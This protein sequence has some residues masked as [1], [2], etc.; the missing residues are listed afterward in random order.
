[1]DSYYEKIPPISTMYIS[2]RTYRNERIMWCLIISK[3]SLN[4]IHRS[5]R[6]KNM[7]LSIPTYLFKS[8]C[9]KIP[10]VDPFSFSKS[11]DTTSD[12]KIQYHYHII[13][14]TYLKSYILI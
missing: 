3:T 2:N 6:G 14:N 9:Y 1:M 10:I 5:C 11:P 7:K 12:F 8:I 13:S 4:G